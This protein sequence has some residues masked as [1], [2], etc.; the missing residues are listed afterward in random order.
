M[1][2]CDF[3]KGRNKTKIPLNLPK[4]SQNVRYSLWICSLI[5][6]LKIRMFE[7]S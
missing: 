2:F 6:D 5:R 7:K 3:K 1:E 4:L